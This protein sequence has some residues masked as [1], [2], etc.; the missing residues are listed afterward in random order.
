MSFEP[1]FRLL[2]DGRLSAL[3]SAVA[4]LKSF[5]K[6]TYLAAA[7]EAGLLNRLAS[8]L[9]TTRSPSSTLSVAVAGR[10][11]RHGCRWVFA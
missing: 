3:L 1:F 8:G 6:L 11:S 2:R 4:E 7:G 10:H 9:A 5:Y